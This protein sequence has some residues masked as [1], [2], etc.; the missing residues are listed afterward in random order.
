MFYSCFLTIAF[1]AFD[2]IFIFSHY[3]DVVHQRHQDKCETRITASPS[4]ASAHQSSCCCRAVT[5]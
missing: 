5:L 3:V 1:L 4:F 2:F